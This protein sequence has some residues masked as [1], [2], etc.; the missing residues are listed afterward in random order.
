LSVITVDRWPVFVTKGIKQIDHE[1]HCKRWEEAEWEEAEMRRSGA[2]TLDRAWRYTTPLDSEALKRWSDLR[3][4]RTEQKQRGET[5]RFKI[6][7]AAGD[8]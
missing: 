3:T 4:L 8:V 1:G 7:S 2:N 6:L 5:L